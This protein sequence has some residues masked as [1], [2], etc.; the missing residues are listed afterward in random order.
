[1]VSGRYGECVT[2]Y[3]STCWHIGFEVL[4]AV[5][6]RNSSFWDTTL[7]NAKSQKVAGLIHDEV[8]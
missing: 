6:V 8:I 4:T 7:H 1:M 2:I 5:A 3:I